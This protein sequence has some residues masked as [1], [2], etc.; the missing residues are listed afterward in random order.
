MW[1]YTVMPFGQC[2][3]SGVFTEAIT[4]ILEKNM[5]VLVLAYLD[6]I[7]IYSKT[8]AEGLNHVQLVLEEFKECKIVCRSH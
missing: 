1:E 7:L 5:N 4:G 8:P 2:N 6:D 3:A